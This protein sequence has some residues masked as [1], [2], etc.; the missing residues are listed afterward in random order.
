MGQYFIRFNKEELRNSIG[1]I[2]DQEVIQN[3]LRE[4]TKDNDDII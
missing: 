2:L 3:Q 4:I 1:L